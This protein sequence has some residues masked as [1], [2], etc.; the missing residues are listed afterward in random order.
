MN[1]VNILAR[2]SRP[3]QRIDRRGKQSLRDE[4]VKSAHHNPKTQTGSAKFTA[5]LPGL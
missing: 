4:A 1:Y 2:G 5:N 3:F